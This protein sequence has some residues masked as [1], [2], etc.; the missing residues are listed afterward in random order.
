MAMARDQCKYR[1]LSDSFKLS[2]TPYQPGQKF[3]SPDYKIMRETEWK[4]L[5]DAK[6]EETDTA[7]EKQA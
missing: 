6:I 4:R 2:K 7:D 3:L 5:H 1:F